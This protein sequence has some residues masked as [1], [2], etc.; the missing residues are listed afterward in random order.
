MEARLRLSKTGDSPGVDATGYRNIIGSLRY[1]INTRLNL[2]YSVVYV[3]RFLEDPREEDMAAMKKILRYVAGTR[4]WGLFYTSGQQGQPC[5]V[6]FS[7][8]DM[9][10]D[11]NDRKSTSGM[12]F[13]LSESPDTWQSS[14]Q[15]DVALSCE[16]EY[17]AAYH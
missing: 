1:L 2:A 14:K 3:S 16:A 6:G 17:I 12:I 10:G 9:S 11:P 15:K 5:L 7:D 8:S 13:F 4:N